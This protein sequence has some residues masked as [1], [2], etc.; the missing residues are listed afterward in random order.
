M[1]LNIAVI[2]KLSRFE[3]GKKGYEEEPLEEDNNDSNL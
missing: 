3:M 1:L 2:F